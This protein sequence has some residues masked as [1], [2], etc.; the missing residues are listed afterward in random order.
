MT[1]A[2]TCTSDYIPALVDA[3]ARQDKPAGIA[4]EV[5][6]D[7]DGVIAQ[8]NVEWA[9]DSKDENIA[10]MCQH[11]AG[12]PSPEMQADADTIKGCLAAASCSDYTACSMPVFEK[13]L[14]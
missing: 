3:R 4:A 9:E 14:R 11:L 5:A 7:R 1:R 2:R 13:K 10:A 8:A 6:K 12:N